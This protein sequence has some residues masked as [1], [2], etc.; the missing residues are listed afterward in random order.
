MSHVTTG[1]VVPG[2]SRVEA[3]RLM[4]AL[5]GGRREIT[6]LRREILGLAEE[7]GR[8]V[9]VIGQSADE[10]LQS[11]YNLVKTGQVRQI[12]LGE[13][14]RGAV[15]R[16]NLAAS[17]AAAVLFSSSRSFSHEIVRSSFEPGMLRGGGW[18]VT[19]QARVIFTSL[20]AVAFLLGSVRLLGGELIP[21]RG[22]AAEV[23]G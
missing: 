14:L 5:G 16:V 12:D 23:T 6:A 3:E 21:D 7:T 4:A 10:C 22:A 2:V 15:G 11:A 8:G 17:Q 18:G 20:A 13:V 1:F 19:L 9:L